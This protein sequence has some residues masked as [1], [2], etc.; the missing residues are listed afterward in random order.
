[1]QSA[2]GLDDSLVKSRIPNTFSSFISYQ[3]LGAQSPTDSDF[4][5]FAQIACKFVWVI[6]PTAIA[7]DGHVTMMIQQP[8]V[9]CH[10]PQH[11][12]IVASTA[13]KEAVGDFDCIQ[14]NSPQPFMSSFITSLLTE[15]GFRTRL[16]RTLQPRPEA[17]A[18]PNGQTYPTSN[19]NG[20]S[21]SREIS[22]DSR[23]IERSSGD[24]GN[25]PAPPFFATLPKE[26]DGRIPEPE[27]SRLA[28]HHGRITDNQPIPVTN[29]HPTG[30]ITHNVSGVLSA[31]REGQRPEQ[32]GTSGQRA[33]PLGTGQDGSGQSQIGA[34]DID[35]LGQ[36]SLPADDGMGWLRKK[37]H[38]IRDLDLNNNEKARMVHELM[39]ESYN[40]TRSLPPVSPSMLSPMLS[41]PGIS[42]SVGSPASEVRQISDPTPTSLKSP[43]SI[44]HYETQFSLTPDDLQPTYVPKVEPE[45]VAEAVDAVDAADA[46]D[47]DPDTEECDEAI[48]GCQH[49]HRNVKLQCH[50][51]KKWYTCRF[52]H[53]AVEDHP[54]IR[55]DTEN[56]LCM[57]CGHPQPAAQNCR[58]CDEQTAQYYCD[59]CK[60]W[61]ND[62]NKSIYHCH[63][64]G[65]CRIGQ[66]LGKDFFHCKVKSNHALL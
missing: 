48:L 46:A 11:L 52:C 51:C 64:C 14:S 8:D 33:P 28:P 22:K 53:D 66:G 58:Q 16:P 36:T 5:V 25:L 19:H 4:M 7:G 26:M 27:G 3:V 38:T 30:P 65:I 47:D 54:L 50:T 57:L 15:L 6:L 13:R 1:M 32:D 2:A 39:T 21:T 23:V 34:L 42:H 20:D 44:P 55:R 35:E 43:A 29:T 49:Y 31:T 63:D 56:M 37:I 41:S 17:E 40:S 45:S 24:A 18:S 9:T 12:S 60:L 10:Q 61:D 59:I 62:S